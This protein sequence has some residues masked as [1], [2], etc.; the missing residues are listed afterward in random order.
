M[1]RVSAKFGY[2]FSYSI[3]IRQNSDG[4]LE[5]ETE[6]LKNEREAVNLVPIY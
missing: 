5:K 2:N 1:Y 4:G 3:Y 6:R